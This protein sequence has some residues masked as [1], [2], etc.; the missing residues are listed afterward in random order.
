MEI[1][2]SFKASPMLQA[3]IEEWERSFWIG[4]NQ[5]ICWGVAYLVRKLSVSEDVALGETQSLSF[6]R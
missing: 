3:L 4:A 2:S 5:H 6:G 1:R